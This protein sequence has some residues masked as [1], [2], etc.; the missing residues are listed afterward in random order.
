WDNQRSI[1]AGHNPVAPG[2]QPHRKRARAVG[3]KLRDLLAVALDDEAGAERS[4]A[5]LIDPAD[6]CNGPTQ[7]HSRQ[8]SRRL[9]RRWTAAGSGRYANTQQQ[10]SHILIIGPA[11]GLT[12][13]TESKH[14]IQI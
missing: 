2:R 6:R 7:H 14:E 5:G 8:S 11:E 9:R 10:R 4:V 12:L 13:R 1:R 3:T